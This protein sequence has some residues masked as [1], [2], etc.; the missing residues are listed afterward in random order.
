MNVC[1]L[2]L[3]KNVKTVTTKVKKEASKLEKT[4]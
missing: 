3:L 4:Y 2:A 1:N